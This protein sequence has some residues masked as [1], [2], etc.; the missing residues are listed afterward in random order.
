[1]KELSVSDVDG[2]GGVTLVTVSVDFSFSCSFNGESFLSDSGGAA[3][4][5]DLLLSSPD[6]EASDFFPDFLRSVLT[7]VSDSSGVDFAFGETMGEVC[8]LGAGRGSTGWRGR[9]RS[10]RGGLTPG[11][12]GAVGSLRPVGKAESEETSNIAIT[13]EV[14]NLVMSKMVFSIAQESEKES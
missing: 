2:L 4:S 10:L 9:L 11:R 3:F 8:G 14:M 1:M 7:G 5:R 12:I 13:K 6:L